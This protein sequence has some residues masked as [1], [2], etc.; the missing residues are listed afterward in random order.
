M[1]TGIDFKSNTTF[2]ASSTYGKY[3]DD[4]DAK[5]RAK[6]KHFFR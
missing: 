1:A 5:W 2:E 3:S 6:M 4:K